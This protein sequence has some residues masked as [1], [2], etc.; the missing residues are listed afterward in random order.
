MSPEQIEGKEA[1]ARSDIFAFGAVLYEMVTGKRPFSGKSQISLASSILESDPQ[2]ISALKPLTPTA[3]EHVV[4]TC[5]QKNPE[6]RYQTAHDIKIELQWIAADK[7]ASAVAAAPPVPA[8]SRER[9]GWAVGV[10]AA[11]LLGAAV[12]VLLFRPP[13]TA[14]A[15]RATIN[16]PA[17]ATLALVGDFAGPPVLSPDGGS[18]AFI[19]TGSDGKNMISVRP[20]N[21]PEAH[22]LAN[23]DG[24]TFPFWSPDSRYLGFFAGAKLKTIDL[25]GGSPLAV[26]DAPFGRGGTWAPGGTILLAPEAQS[27]IM[28]VSASGGT[29][30][31]VTKVDPAQTSHRWPFFLPD[32]KHFLY[33]FVDAR[34]PATDAVYY[35][36]VDGR[37]KS[38]LITSQSNAIYADGFLLFMRGGQ[39]MAQPFDPA[40]GTLSGE[41]QNLASGVMED[42]STWHMDAS[43]A[44][45]GL[46]VFSNGGTGDQQMVWVDRSGK[47]IA[48]VVKKLANL[49]SAKL[50]PQADR[51]ALEID[52]GPGAHDIWVYDIAREVQTRLTFGSLENDAPIWSPD[53]KWIVYTSFESSLNLH[54]KLYRKPSD[55]SGAPE[56]LLS[57]DQVAYATDWSRDG[58]YLLYARGPA[59]NYWEVWALP[60]EGERKPWMVVPRSAPGSYANEGHLSPDGHWLAYTSVESG[61]PEVYVGAF[62]GG[63]GKW[64]ISTNGG[65]QPQWSRDGKELYYFNQ[66]SRSVLA[67]PGKEVGGGLQFG[68]AQSLA[69]N[70]LSNSS[71]FYDLTPDGKKILLNLVSQQVSQS[72]TVITNFT[73]GLKK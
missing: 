66:A 34:D 24:A 67:V 15:I 49:L 10:V 50:S 28:R 4:T 30:I 31:P 19:A 13:Q 21:A 44:G 40:K 11:I 5:L 70:S 45:N 64:Q 14:P 43:A 51:I 2:P 48:T 41:M 47:Q 22:M 18:I 27:P 37:E 56:L 36:S 59:A 1:D 69:S 52:N 73:A 9:L 16:P 60:L 57:D 54:A 46:L 42:A 12:G 33:L 20:L 63:Q 72:V 58:K 39:L 26:C 35:A 29:P 8:R 17:N 32:G 71:G 38:K 7:S 25:N 62:R 61:N 6:E 55:G 68:A 3:F 23:T 53:G 65:Y